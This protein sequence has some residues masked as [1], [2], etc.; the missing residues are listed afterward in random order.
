M[1]LSKENSTLNYIWGIFFLLE[2]F[3]G[4]FFTNYRPFYPLQILGIFFLLSAVILIPIPLILFPRKRDEKKH[5][6]FFDVP[7]VISTGIYGV[8]R[9]PQ[10]LGWVFIMIG[11][12]FLRQEFVGAIFG[13]LGLVFLNYC[14]KIEESSLII[15]FG[16]DYEI[17]RSTVP[18]WN[19][20]LGI[21]R[22][23]LKRDD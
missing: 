18:R 7:Q 19:L 8:V 11:L 5:D 20:I 21:Y 6:H 14:A 3:S 2:I 4:E 13:F 17:Y 15:K 12:F 23:F 9:H 1:E 10:Y 16:E 22:Y